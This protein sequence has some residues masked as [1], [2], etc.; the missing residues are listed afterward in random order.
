[1]VF[2]QFGV[3]SLQYLLMMPPFSLLGQIKI[4]IMEAK[5]VSCHIFGLIFPDPL[6]HAPPS[7]GHCLLPCLQR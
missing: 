3:G 7:D 5:P 1:M 2:G 6:G 4:L